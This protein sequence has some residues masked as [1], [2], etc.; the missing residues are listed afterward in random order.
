MTLKKYTWI[1]MIIAGIVLAIF[2]YS[3]IFSPHSGNHPVKCVHEE[4]LGS[5][6][7]T[8][9]MSQAFSAIVRLQFENARTLQPNS[10]SVFLFFFLQLILRAAFLLLLKAKPA[11]LKIITIADLPIA[12]IMFIFFFRSIIYQTFYIFYK[13]LLTGM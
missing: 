5:R 2:L 10:I 8:C 4:L 9:G 6:C 12:L 11:F 1:N 3:A 13:M 7:P